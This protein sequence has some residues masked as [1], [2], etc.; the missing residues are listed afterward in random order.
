[1]IDFFRLLAQNVGTAVF[2]LDRFQT[3]RFTFDG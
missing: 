2:L 1:M 3:M